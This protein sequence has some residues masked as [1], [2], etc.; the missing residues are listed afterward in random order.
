MNQE[1]STNP[2]NPVTPPK[3][4]D[5]IKVS[6]ASPER[7]LSWS[8]G[9]IKKPETINYRTFKPERDGLF[10]AR[11]FGPIKDYECLCGK[12]KRMKYRGVVCEKCGVEVT[13]QKVRRER[14]GHIEL[15]SPVAHIWFLKSLPSRIG[16]MLDMTLRDLERILYFENYVVIEPGL[17]DLTY[18]QLMNE[19]EF[20]D[21][22][23][24]YGMDAFT[25]NIGAEA[26]REMLSL[27][28]LDGEAEQLRVDLSVA[29]GELKPKK[30][31][32]RL[33][34]VES[35][36]ESGNRPEWMILTVIPVIPPELRP[37]VP[38]DG[39]RFATSD[40][41]DLYRRVINRNNRLKRLIEL[42]APDIIVRNEK[43]MLQESVDA[44]FDNGRRGRVIT[45]QNKR[46][47]KSLSD[48]L[49]GKQGRF[50]QNLLGKRVDFSG[51][52]VIVTG[53]EL[54]LHQCGLP[55]KMAL[56]LF[57]PFIY[58]RL[59]AKGLSS[60]VK[61]A[62]KL[63]EKERPEVWDILDEV[64]REHP[65]MLNRAPTLHRL[66]IQAFEPVLIEGKAIQLH[67]LVCSA[68]N[69]D[70]DGDQMA[71]HVPLSLEAQLEA[72][73]L[74]MSTNNVLSPA[75]GAP[76]I[77]PSQDMILG[78]YYTTL[79]RKGMKGEDMIFGSVDEVQHALDAGVVHLHAK[80]T[81]RIPQV[82]DEGNQ[83]MVR[84]ETTPGRVRLGDLLPQNAKAPFSLVNRLLKK[85]EVQ[86]VIDTVYRYCGQKESVI[87]CDHVMTIGFREAFR[88]GISFGKDD[89]LIPDNK[90]TIVDGVRAQVKEFEQQYMD[91]LITQGEK[92]NKVIDAWSNCNDQVTDSMMEAIASVKYD[93]NGSEME[94][95]SVYMM[96]HSKARGSVTQ[97]KQLGGMRGLMAK[98]N[99]DIIETP[100]ISNFKE[101]LTVLEYFNSTHGARKGLSDTALKTA[102]SGYLTRRLV[103]V[104]QDCIV[105]SHDCGTERSITARA[106]VNDG[107]V[108][109][110]LAERILGRVAAEDVIKPGT[111]EVLCT[112]NQII[113]ER[114]ADFIEAGGVISMLIRSPLTCETDD[115]ICAACY[116]R[117]LAR[118]TLVN[119]GEAVGI[120]AA[121]SI[122][123]PGTQLTM[124]T[125]HIGGVAQGGGQQSS[126]ES[127]QSGKVHLENANLLKN[128][129]GEF[130]SLTRNM[131]A[132]I[133]DVGGA[134]IASYKVAYG[135][136]MLV[137]DGQTIARGD[138]LF[139][140]D[141]FTLPIIAEKSGTVKYVDLVSGIAVRDETDDATGMTQK[142]VTD[143]RA[144][145]KGNELAPK[146]IV[147]D[148][149]GEM[150]VRKDGNPIAYAM[151]VDAVLSVE[152]AQ[153]IKAGD[154]L[155]RIPREGGRSKDITGGLP[156]VAELFEA[157]RPKD[158]AI[159]AEID[160]YV[161]FGKDYKNKRRIAIEPADD[162]MEK[163]E[164]MVPKGKH[165]PVQEGDFIKKGDYIMDGNPAPHD[166]LAVMGVEAL[167]DYMIDE[168]QDV[169]RLQGVKINDKHIE[170]IVRQ[171]LQKW[172]ITE[173]GDT[174]LLKGE[175]VDKAEFDA[176]NDK[177]LSK[178]GRQAQ[179]EPILLG[180]TKASLQTRS[181]ISAAS[182]QETT[183]VLTEAS[184]QGKRDKLVGLKEN[185][186]VGR[187]IPAG[188]GGATQQMRKV[189]TDRD[190]VVI[191]A[192]RAE[193]E[194]AIALAA[195]V[196]AAPTPDELFDSLLADKAENKEA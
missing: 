145:L 133:L 88:A 27:I 54:K 3:A 177:S 36:I 9:E 55:K 194:E 108:I 90:W 164:Y 50:R 93:E 161:R 101:G 97:M 25:A 22:Q 182:F 83:I 38:L 115:G 48:M 29:T 56:E 89:M 51:R 28:D 154:I 190:N 122:G 85:G 67:P 109:S 193:A 23:D 53:P 168:V 163:V 166:I 131:V 5:E 144:A 113:D 192:R 178:G 135:S 86:Q 7:I 137:K 18:G 179:G 60:T 70:F 186:I 100:I 160:G 69:A 118:G 114:K 127:S 152:D 73:V 34:I 196:Q 146:I 46:P 74:M 125:F 138:K 82:D 32:K 75:N 107:E 15:A 175:H 58:S 185:V 187:L 84:F 12:Y 14:M 173:S 68:F 79:M 116:G 13:L 1:L 96:A 134:V 171:M 159:I 126:Q 110:S 103:D 102:N 143:W 81:A 43:R 150:L 153:E 30:I 76:I 104:A 80:I 59:E 188:T 158:H 61:Q 174:T 172:E 120:I 169:Y 11:I 123:E 105:R 17:T 155:A 189:A 6:L 142:I 4:F 165:I 119:Q 10:C 181:F 148:A 128:S 156:R 129:A 77:V 162:T 52:S 121:Q 20:L 24:I 33:K 49:K 176:A 92:Y 26:I 147:T 136:K 47:L 44:L 99:G 63:V 45:G 19:E 151:S 157:R 180:I 57:K 98:P 167:A 139:E 124:R 94:P 62:K 2:F 16:L 91:G 184:V 21:A 87:F 111:D 8:F 141:P 64:I 42:R 41:N 40:L 130:L 31:I 183:R 106:A 78:L 35:F 39:G 149:N 195:P 66:G 170:V 140:W 71:V 112:K 191:E 37:L 95:N 117:D 132:S 72:R 65:V